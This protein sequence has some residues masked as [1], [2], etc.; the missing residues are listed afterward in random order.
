MLRLAPHFRSKSIPL[1]LL[2]YRYLI[3]PKLEP[4]RLEVVTLKLLLYCLLL[5]HEVVLP[6]CGFV[7]LL[8]WSLLVQS[9][10]RFDHVFFRNIGR[11]KLLLEQVLPVGVSEPNVIFEFLCPV[12]AKSALRTPL[13]KLIC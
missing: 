13:Q 4:R 11:L 10:A 7:E 6:D 2:L 1:N 5:D 9:V 12:E 8:H 3:C